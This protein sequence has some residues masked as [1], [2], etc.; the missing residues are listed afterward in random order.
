MDKWRPDG[1]ENPHGKWIA[2]HEDYFPGWHPSMYFVH[3]LRRAS[4]EA[5]AD[6]M[7]EA[8]TKQSVRFRF[9]KEGEFDFVFD[10]DPAFNTDEWIKGTLVF[11]PDIDNTKQKS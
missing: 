11:I 1:W 7:L 6:A 10:V 9:H 2:E 4:F 3:D 5:G 8:L